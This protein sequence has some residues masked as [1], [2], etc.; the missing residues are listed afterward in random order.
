[1]KEIKRCNQCKEHY[2]DMDCKSEYLVYGKWVCADC[3]FST[4]ENDAE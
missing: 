4:V 2:K 3:Y 1:M